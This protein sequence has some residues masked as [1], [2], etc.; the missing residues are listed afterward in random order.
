MN[1][2]KNKALILGTTSALMAS[3]LLGCSNDNS[4]KS[5]YVVIRSD[6]NAIVM[7]IEKAFFYEGFQRIVLKNG[8]VI[9]TDIKDTFNVFGDNAKEEAYYL[10]GLLV[11]ENGEIIEYNNDELTLKK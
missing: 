11:G 5:K 2:M 6:E 10:A 7:E 1:K 9:Y 3:V 8:D 4:S